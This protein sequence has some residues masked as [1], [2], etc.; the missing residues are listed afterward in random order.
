MDRKSREKD[1]NRE[2]IEKELD[3]THTLTHEE[4]TILNAKQCE[5]PD[6]AK[7]KWPKRK[8]WEMR[9]H[10]LA[11]FPKSPNRPDMR[12]VREMLKKLGRDMKTC[13][14]CGV[15]SKKLQVHH[16]DHNPFNNGPSNLLMLCRH[17]HGKIHDVDEDVMGIKSEEYTLGIMEE[18]V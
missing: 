9:K 11:F 14:S 15:R 1:S 4:L 8:K 6:K 2:A 12:E 17:C 18:D 5:L 3:Y 7:I 16:K 13:Q 10:E